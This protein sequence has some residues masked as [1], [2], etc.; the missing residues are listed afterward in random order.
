[1]SIARIL[2]VGSTDSDGGAL[3]EALS[4]RGHKVTVAPDARAGLTDLEAQSFDVLITVAPGN[5]PALPGLLQGLAA[6]E[7]RLAV[8]LI[9]TDS[10]PPPRE[11]REGLLAWLASPADPDLVGHLVERGTELRRL[12]AQNTRLGT[13]LAARLEDL[14]QTREKALQAGR[15]ATLGLLMADVAHELNN[16]LNV[17]LGFSDLVMEAPHD[18]Q[19][20]AEAAQILSDSANRAA[21]TV[22]KLLAIARS[23]PPQLE[24]VDMRAM[25]QAALDWRQH[26][27]QLNEIR[28]VLEVEPDLPPVECD[29][30][31]L[32]QVMIHLLLNAEQAIGSQGEIVIRIQKI[33]GD[34]VEVSVADSG[35]GVPPEDL[36][37]IFRPFYT[38]RLP[39]E[40]TGL[41]LASC[42]SI[43]EGHNGA[44]SARNRPEG[45]L[46]VVFFIPLLPPGGDAVPGAE[47]GL[48][49]QARLPRGLRVLVLEDDPLGGELLFRYLAR[50]RVQAQ[51]CKSGEEGLRALETG[52][53][54]AVICDLRM[55]GIGGEGFF[56]LLSERDP[57]LARCVIFVTGDALNPKAERFLA[58]SGCAHLIKPF[59]P[60]E[61]LEALITCLPV[62]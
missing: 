23:R 1:M 25:A 50:V 3:L 47:S 16:P 62:T 59:S 56:H 45:G 48:D 31:Q 2:W 34:R 61:L 53:Y 35:P 6:T 4:A 32:H 36:G 11:L 58:E 28:V 21:A 15:L 27:L 44:I 18:R 51:V 5:D 39:E 20:V 57:S 9:T 10:N 14:Q 12:L 52:T 46:E 30:H 26:H 42:A 8:L 43:I 24:M 40:G 22:R 55:P 17:I 19:A 13:A 38:T 41:G 60:Q 33:P 7:S 37:R 29:R 54:H 49:L